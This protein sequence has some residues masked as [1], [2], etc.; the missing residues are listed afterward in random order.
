MQKRTIGPWM[1]CLAF[2]LFSLEAM[3][4]DM[5]IS[6]SLSTSAGLVP[7]NWG[8]G[9]GPV[10]D[11]LDFNQFNSHV[12]TLTT[13]DL[14]LTFNIRNDYL[15][16]FVNTPIPTT[17]YRATSMT[18][19]PSVLSDPAQ[20]AMLTDGNTVTLLAANGSTLLGPPSTRQPVDF[21]KMT[22]PSEPG[23]PRRP[24]TKVSSRRR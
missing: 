3:A 6:Q 20:R 22:E 17:L 13:I 9:Y 8:D 19:A 4:G 16:T 18:S 14:T 23:R 1:L 2:S 5:T 7:T 10:T 15:M 11:P 24:A 21:V 12:G